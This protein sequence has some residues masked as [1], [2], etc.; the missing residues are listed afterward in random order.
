VGG[1]RMILFEEEI[2]EDLMK[3]GVKIDMSG[4]KFIEM[5]SCETCPCKN[6]NED[7]ESCNLG[8]ETSYN[9]IIEKHPTEMAFASL[10]YMILASFNCGLEIVKHSNGGYVP[11]KVM[12][13]K[14][15]VEINKDVLKWG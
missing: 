1:G 14:R 15:R 3:N 7:E 10:D 6:K 9:W 2:V 5:T 11:V 13:H 8:Y 12:A 4:D